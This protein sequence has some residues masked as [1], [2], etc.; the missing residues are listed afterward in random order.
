MK[1]ESLKVNWLYSITSDEITKNYMG[2]FNELV[3][4]N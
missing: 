2:T 1:D 3:V 4:L